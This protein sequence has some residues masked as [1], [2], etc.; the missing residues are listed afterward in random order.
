MF[1]LIYCSIFT[2]IHVKEKYKV[3]ST[4][5]F[6]PIF[7]IIYKHNIKQQYRFACSFPLSSGHLTYKKQPS[8]PH[9]TIVAL[10]WS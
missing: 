8:C 3:N 4:Y 1:V 9:L 2:L 5:Q 6:A 7:I 10:S